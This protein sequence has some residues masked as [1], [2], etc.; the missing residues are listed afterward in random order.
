MQGVI[1]FLGTGTS[2]GVPV[3]GCGCAVCRSSDPRDA[4][5]RSSAMVDV[6]ATRLLIDA[7]PDLRQQMLSAHVDRLDAVLL[8]HEHMD[9]IGGIDDLRA[10]NF[11]QRRAMDI[12]GNA[13]TLEA[14]RHMYHYAFGERVY[15]GVP[16]LALHAVDGAFTIGDARIEP[17]AVL[18][19]RMPVLGYRIGGLAY[20]T[21]ANHIADEVVER[22]HGIDVLVLNALRQSEHPTHF[23]L[24][25]ALA[26]VER[27]APKRA[28]FTH[29]SHL[30]GTNA[31]VSAELPQGVELATDGLRIDFP[32]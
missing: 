28:C 12:H 32:A 29:I 24:Q 7:G 30:L 10:F 9:H 22:L 17:F 1:T 6:G 31:E 20:I 5:L 11:R 8:T 14:V 3:I 16:E 26:M 18:H 2:Q 23:N 4:R 27:I 21:D 15:P 13:A 25:Q 19:G